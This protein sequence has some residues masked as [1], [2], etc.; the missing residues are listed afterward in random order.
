MADEAPQDLEQVY[1]KY[2]PVLLGALAALVRQGF[3][4]NPGEGL[5]VVHDFY[6]EA[7]PGLFERYEPSQAKFSTYLYGAFLRFARGR[8]I[9]HQRWNRLLVPFDDAIAHPAAPE[10]SSTTEVLNARVAGALRALPRELRITIEARVARGESEREIARR[11]RVTRY[12]V[13]QRLAEALGRIA[14]AIGNDETIREDLRPLAIRLWRDGHSLMRVAQEQ[15]LTRSEARQRLHELIGSL[16][17]AV[18]SL[19]S[20]G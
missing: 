17:A 15:D 19:G 2:T 4:L 10:D 13:R 8:I 7:L 11:L 3:R 16:S 12:V 14:V 18:R 6:I 9:R 1:E 20:E 5:E